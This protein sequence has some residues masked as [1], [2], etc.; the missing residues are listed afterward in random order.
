[1]DVFT[2]RWYPQGGRIVPGADGRF[3][4]TI[5]LGGQEE[6]HCANLIRARLFDSSGRE[7]NS[8]AVFSVARAELDGSAPACTQKSEMRKP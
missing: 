8:S 5:Y 4:Q 1:V 6:M 7:L 2:N 3:A